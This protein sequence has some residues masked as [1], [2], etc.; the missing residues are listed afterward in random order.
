MLK[1]TNTAQI[2]EELMERYTGFT[3]WMIQYSPWADVEIQSNSNQIPPGYFLYKL[4]ADLKMY[5]KA[6]RHK[7][8]IFSWLIFDISTKSIQCI[9]KSLFNK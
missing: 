6:N 1:T 9:N 7:R 5:E 8:Y 3:V 2:K 4:N